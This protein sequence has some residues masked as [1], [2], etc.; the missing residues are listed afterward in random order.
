MDEESFR[1]GLELLE[2]LEVSLHNGTD[3]H[4]SHMPDFLSD[5][6]MVLSHES[7]QRL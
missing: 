7:W 2:L 5:S 4:L 6:M 3:P 1:K